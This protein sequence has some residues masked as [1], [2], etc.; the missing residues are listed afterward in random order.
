MCVG[1]EGALCDVVNEIYL[2]SKSGRVDTVP[3]HICGM[4]VGDAPLGPSFVW[5][6]HA[7][8]S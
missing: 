4:I 3:L 6:F 8:L 5:K 7:A 2:L 1:A